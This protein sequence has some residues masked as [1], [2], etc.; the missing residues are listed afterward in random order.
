MTGAALA[1]RVSRRVGLRRQR[2]ARIRLWCERQGLA[3]V[4]KPRKRPG[5]R[6]LAY[7]WV[8]TPE[9]GVNDLPPRRFGQQL[10]WALRA[11]YQFVPPRRIADGLGEANELAVTFDDGVASVVTNAGPILWDLGIPGRSS[12]PPIMPM[13]SDPGRKASRREGGAQSQR[14]PRNGWPATWK[15]STTKCYPKKGAAEPAAPQPPLNPD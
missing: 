1:K 5:G 10:D 15:P 9:W 4:K 3:A 11:G 2:V 13:D 8:G 6:I 7:H 14:L 12:L